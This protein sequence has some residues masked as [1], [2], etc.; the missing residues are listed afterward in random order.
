MVVRTQS[1]FIVRQFHCLLSE[2]HSSLRPC[3]LKELV[4]VSD[5]LVDLGEL[6]RGRFQIYDALYTLSESFRFLQWRCPLRR[7]RI[8]LSQFCRRFSVCLELLLI[9]NKT[10]DLTTS[11]ELGPV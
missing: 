4:A 8:F 10:G 1:L 7:L 6:L 11:I 9:L 3:L 2:R 5:D